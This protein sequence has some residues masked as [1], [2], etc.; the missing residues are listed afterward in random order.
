MGPEGQTMLTDRDLADLEA[1]LPFM[2]KQEQA[3]ALALLEADR[4]DRFLKDIPNDILN[5]LCDV[6]GAIQLARGAEAASISPH[7]CDVYRILGDDG[8]P[9]TYA[10]WRHRDGQPMTYRERATIGPL[11]RGKYLADPDVDPWGPE[12]VNLLQATMRDRVLRALARGC[13]T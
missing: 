5:A 4:K 2:T 1:A 13:W 11:T 6:A 12:V 7:P 3:E 9:L 10:E 8:K